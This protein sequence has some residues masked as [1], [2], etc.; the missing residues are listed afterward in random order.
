MGG[1]AEGKKKGKKGKASGPKKLHPHMK[2]L[3]IILESLDLDSLSKEVLAS[4]WFVNRDRLMRAKDHAWWQTR[5]IKILAIITAL[6]APVLMFANKDFSD[7]ADACETEC[8]DS[9]NAQCPMDLFL[10]YTYFTTTT[11]PHVS[12][13]DEVEKFFV[14]G[15]TD[16]AWQADSSKELYPGEQLGFC[17]CYCDC[18]PRTNPNFDECYWGNEMIAAN[19]L[20]CISAALV[21]IDM[22]YRVDHKIDKQVNA[23]SE[24]SSVGWE[25]ASLSGDFEGYP[26]HQEA[27]ETFVHE[28]E[29]ILGRLPPSVLPNDYIEI[30]KE[31]PAKT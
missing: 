25:F 5:I 22:F 2:N 10:R 23:A 3:E 29:L 16:D 9:C 31:E 4:R 1:N 27:F 7:C 17:K 18:D 26:S 24:L 14:Q 19:C 8:Q 12:G 11:G 6:S 20:I 21:L 30:S 15:Y 28:T 13:D